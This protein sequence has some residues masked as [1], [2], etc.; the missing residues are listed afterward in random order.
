MVTRVMR[1]LIVTHTYL[2]ASERNV[3]DRGPE[4]AGLWTLRSFFHQLS[5]YY[6]FAAGLTMATSLNVAL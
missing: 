2:P 5:E 1:D 6:N 3:R 4:G